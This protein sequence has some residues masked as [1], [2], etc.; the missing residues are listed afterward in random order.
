VLAEVTGRGCCTT[1]RV[2][3][4]LATFAERHVARLRRDAAALDLAPPDADAVVG[5]F[6]TLGRAVFGEAVGVVRLQVVP[7]GGRRGTGTSRLVGTARPLGPEPGTWRAVRASCPHP[8][9]APA[10]GAKLAARPAW[11]EAR[12]RARACGVDEALLCDADGRLVEGARSNVLLVDAAGRARFPDPAL[13]AV[14]GIGL[15]VLRDAT[16]D[17]AP[18]HLGATNVR[19]ARELVAVNAVRGVRPI[20]ALDDAPV[21]DG[22]PGPVA[23]RLAAAFEAAAQAESRPSR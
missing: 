7:G 17:L 23:R 2:A 9:P 13:G 1:A 19:S 8:G 12:D 4:G 5:A 14:A 18:G 16:D 20:V 15:A 3:A 6:R 21:G 22:G 11:D 10:P